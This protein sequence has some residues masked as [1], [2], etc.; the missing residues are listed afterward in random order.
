MWTATYP[1][2]QGRAGLEGHDHDH[3][4]SKAGELWFASAWSGTKA[5]GQLLGGGNLV[6]R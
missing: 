6:V 1:V 5:V 4:W 3:G 2:D